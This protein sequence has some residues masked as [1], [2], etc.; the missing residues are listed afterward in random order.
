MVILNLKKTGG[1]RQSGSAVVHA[2][3]HDRHQEDLRHA[4]SLGFL[5]GGRKGIGRV[6]MWVI[7]VS[8]LL[9]NSP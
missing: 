4:L 5:L 3:H 2:E 8:N 9:T 6:I 7:G 1:L